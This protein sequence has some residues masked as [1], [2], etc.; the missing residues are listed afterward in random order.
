MDRAGCKAGFAVSSRIFRPPRAARV[1]QGMTTFSSGRRSLGTLRL[2]AILVEASLANCNEKKTRTISDETSDKTSDEAVPTEVFDIV[3]PESRTNAWAQRLDHAHGARQL[4]PGG[5]E[6]LVRQ[7]IGLEVHAEPPDAGRQ[8]VPTFCVLRQGR[9]REGV[10]IAV[11]RA[12]GG[13]SVGLS[14]P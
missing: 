12:P 13:V 10:T 3:S 1:T 9:R 2:A 8:R 5:D 14:G 6:G 4:Q 11:V 7:G